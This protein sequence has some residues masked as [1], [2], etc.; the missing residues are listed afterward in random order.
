MR[1]KLPLFLKNWPGKRQKVTQAFW[2][3][4]GN[5]KIARVVSLF[6]FNNLMGHF[7][8]HENYCWLLLAKIADLFTKK[9]VVFV[10]VFVYLYFEGNM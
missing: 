7:L 1:L 2:S 6:V 8:V 10:F 4:F 3:Y 9:Y 5:V